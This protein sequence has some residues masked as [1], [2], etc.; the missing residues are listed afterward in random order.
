[1]VYTDDTLNFETIGDYNEMNEVHIVISGRDSKTNVQTRRINP[2]D[3]NNVELSM[4][5]R[6]SPIR[7]DP[8][9]NHVVSFVYLKS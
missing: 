8:L 4:Q 1:M 3:F 2:L 7:L 9:T 5:F 6:Q